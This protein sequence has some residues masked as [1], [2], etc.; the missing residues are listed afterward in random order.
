[1]IMPNVAN[2]NL[3]PSIGKSYTIVDW[4]TVLD[5]TRLSRCCL[6][7]KEW[8]P[9]FNKRKFQKNYRCYFNSNMPDGEEIKVNRVFGTKDADGVITVRNYEIYILD[10]MHPPWNI[11][12]PD[13]CFVGPDG[14]TTVLLSK[15]PNRD[16]DG[17]IPEIASIMRP[18]TMTFPEGFDMGRYINA[19]P[20]GIV[21]SLFYKR[22][23]SNGRI[24]GIWCCKIGSRSTRSSERS[25]KSP[26][27]MDSVDSHYP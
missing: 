27:Y 25:K 3:P 5:T 1:M 21:H 8:M 13:V 20:P 15:L 10:S 6:Y 7:L 26:Q 17:S 11:G 14:W 4:L 18:S 12:I 9:S 2:T 22:E 24:L 23:G 19:Y 16:C